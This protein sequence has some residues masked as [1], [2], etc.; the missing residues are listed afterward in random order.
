[1][2]YS[3]R[4]F[5]SP[6][7]QFGGTSKYRSYYSKQVFIGKSEIVDIISTI[8][9]WISKNEA[10]KDIIGNKKIYTGK[11]CDIPRY[12]IKDFIDANHYHR[13]SKIHHADNIIS[14]KAPFM[15]MLRELKIY[16]KNK[17]TDYIAIP[18]TKDNQELLCGLIVNHEPYVSSKHQHHI[19]LPVVESKHFPDLIP[20]N[21]HVFYNTNLLDMF[22]F[23]LQDK[24]VIFDDEFNNIIVEDNDFDDMSFENFELISNVITSNDADNISLAINLMN[25]YNVAK[26]TFYISTI[27]NLYYNNLFRLKD[28]SK[29]VKPLNSNIKS[30]TNYLDTQGINYKDSWCIF[31]ENI[32]P[33]VGDDLLDNYNL[34]LNKL[35]E[36]ELRRKGLKINLNNIQL[37]HK[38]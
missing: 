27:L 8:E 19:L 16:E 9:N 6:T 28:S 24:H 18:D 30:I 32:F 2:I 37:K 23:V 38:L 3:S 12:V 7:T 29:T 26:D 14:S 1:M 34:I 22:D 15:T 36:D 11:Y 10:N 17:P 33:L 25:N 35:V 20:D 4:K 21:Y 5:F 31:M 13:T